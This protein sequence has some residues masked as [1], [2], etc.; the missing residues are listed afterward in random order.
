MVKCYKESSPS[1][2]GEYAMK[3]IKLYGLKG[4]CVLQVPNRGLLEKWWIYTQ[5][6]LHGGEDFV[7]AG[8]V[9]Q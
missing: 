7:Q 5:E 8:N 1:D 3:V 6:I 2:V 4:Y 9:N